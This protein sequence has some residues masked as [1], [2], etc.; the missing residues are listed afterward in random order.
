MGVPNILSQISQVREHESTAPIV[1]SQQSCE[2]PSASEKAN[3]ITLDNEN[4]DKLNKEEVP[5]KFD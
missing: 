2:H 3:K 4:L 5:L 1:K